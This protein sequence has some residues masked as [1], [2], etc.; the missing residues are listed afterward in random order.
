MSAFPTSP[1]NGQTVTVNSVTY[2]YNSTYNTWNRVTVP[3]AIT[4]MNVNGTLLLNNLGICTTSPRGSL[5]LS[6]ST[7]ALI[8]GGTIY[9][10]HYPCINCYKILV[11]SGIKEIFYINDYKNDE[12]VQEFCN[13]MNVKTNKI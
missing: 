12:L 5:D 8:D 2:I 3:V 4:S 9:I 11:A 7:G 6:N 10:T 13:Q 1:V